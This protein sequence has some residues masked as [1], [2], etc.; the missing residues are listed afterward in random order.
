MSLATDDEIIMAAYLLAD[1]CTV[2]STCLFTNATPEVI[3]EFT[4]VGD[5]LSDPSKNLIRSNTETGVIECARIGNTLTLRARGMSWFI[6]KFNLSGKAINKKM[7]RRFKG[8]DERQ[9]CLFL[10]RFWACD[11]W[12]EKRTGPAITLANEGLIQDLQKMLAKI[13]IHIGYRHKPSRFRGKVFDAWRLRI[14][15]KKDTEQF[16]RKVGLV[17][18]KERACADV[19]AYY[20]FVRGVHERKNK[21]LEE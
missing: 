10:N 4:E 13:D 6:R 14:V 21:C 12:I 15:N 20:F 17:L 19:L 2:G 7:P 16:F 9:I 8:L 3:K 18:G 5:R 11:G 1:G